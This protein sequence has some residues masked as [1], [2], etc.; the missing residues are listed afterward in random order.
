MKDG[1]RSS[2]VLKMV[3]GK[4]KKCRILRYY[5]EISIIF[6]SMIVQNE[7]FIIG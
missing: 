6:I 3:C 4:K 5:T 7:K 2:G 1:V